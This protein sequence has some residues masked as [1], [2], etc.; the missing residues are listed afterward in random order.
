MK[1]IIPSFAK[2][3]L[4]L[5]LALVCFLAIPVQSQVA[6]DTPQPTST[7]NARVKLVNP[8]ISPWISDCGLPLRWSEFD[9][10][11]SKKTFDLTS[12]CVFPP[13][14]SG[15]EALPRLS[16][17][18][19]G[20]E[21][22]IN[23]NGYSI[24]GPPNRTFLVVGGA[25]PTLGNHPAG[26]APTV[27]LNLNDVTIRGTGG[28]N[29]RTA[30]IVRG[31]RFNANNVIFRDNVGQTILS[32]RD[33]GKAHLTNVQFLNNQK[34]YGEAHWGSTIF[35]RDDVVAQASDL[36]DTRVNINGAVFRRNSGSVL[37]IS[38]YQANLQLAGSIIFENNAATTIRE[39]LP[40]W[41]N[42]RIYHWPGLTQFQGEV[43]NTA[44]ITSTFNLVPWRPKKKE[45]PPTP[46][47][48]STPRPQ[49][50]ATHV[51]L[52][53]ATGAT[54]STAFG[55]DSG[56]HFR[57]LDGAG[58]GV[59]SIIDAGFLEAFD[60]YGYVEQG[61]DVCFPQIGRVVFL[62][63]N[64]SPRAIV[65]LQANIVNGQT[66]VSINSPGSLVLLPQ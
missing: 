28:I 36:N 50:A 7:P 18:Y 25:H 65:P 60:V 22:T 23:G 45:E 62:D 33:K 63:A 46:A 64:T 42:F 16:F 40:V 49:I 51:A 20:G 14:P 57:Q 24:I 58:I 12:D 21:F 26:E 30:V 38:G 6:T 1:F 37:V 61:V 56:V 13:G 8:S 55:L 5:C 41:Y 29:G 32:V 15:Q 11:A 2:S 59:Q 47:P 4:F 10:S 53:A 44:T 35:V 66:C 52:Q 27:T 54:F 43:T 34:T 48:T 39:A 9:G 17:I 19:G 31:A 3:S